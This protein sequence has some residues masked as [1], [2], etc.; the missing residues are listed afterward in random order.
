MH[1]RR[2]ALTARARAGQACFERIRARWPPGTAFCAIGDGAEERMAAAALAWPFVPVCATPPA[3]AAPPGGA[4]GPRGGAGAQAPPGGQPLTA[5][6][7]NAVLR[8]A[9]CCG[10]GVA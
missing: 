2:G 4:P 10:G 6:T 3:C 1:A 7:A 9:L 8:A 5:L